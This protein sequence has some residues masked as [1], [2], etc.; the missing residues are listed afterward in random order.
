ME[1]PGITSRALE[2]G[3][4]T[5]SGKIETHMI[6]KTLSQYR[7]LEKL[8]QGGMGTVYVAEDTSLH[9]KVALKLL[10]PEMA[11]HGDR[12]RRFQQEARAVAA[13]NH[14]NIVTVH[15]VEESDGHHFITME[16]VRGRPLG[17][18]IPGDGLP[19]AKLLELAVPLADAVAAAHRKGIVHRDLKPD[20][21][22]IDDEGPSLVEVRLG[23]GQESVHEIPFPRA[24]V[25]QDLLDA[26]IGDAAQKGPPVG[27][28]GGRA[29]KRRIPVAGEFVRG[30]DEPGDCRSVR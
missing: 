10:P 9:R 14:P 28:R 15:S 30:V 4:P 7:I 5:G 13:L 23:K 21:V 26:G 12:L 6:G 27:G 25:E 1:G 22:M 3:C 16:L 17:D 29:G 11:G 8:G 20:N 19:A 2:P 24:S 18:L